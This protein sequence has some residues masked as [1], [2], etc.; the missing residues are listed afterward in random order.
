MGDCLN[1]MSKCYGTFRDGG[2]TC[3][4]WEPDPPPI[5]LSATC[6]AIIQSRLAPVVQ[7]DHHWGPDGR[8][9]RGGGGTL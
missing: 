1:D 8:P 9:I 3:S 7:L 6:A 2:K 5:P 4:K